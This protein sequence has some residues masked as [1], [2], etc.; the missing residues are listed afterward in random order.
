MKRDCFF[1]CQ[2]LFN[3]FRSEPSSQVTANP[4]SINVLPEYG[5]DPR[6]PDKLVDGGWWCLGHVQALGMGHSVTSFGLADPS[7]ICPARLAIS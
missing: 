4:E 3:V 2:S 7:P 6:T 5:S 1:Q